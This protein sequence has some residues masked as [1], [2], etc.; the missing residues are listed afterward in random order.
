MGGRTAMA[1]EVYP[2]RAYPVALGEV[3][4]SRFTFPLICDVADVLRQHGYPRGSAADL[5]VLQQ[6]L[7]RFL[8]SGG[9]S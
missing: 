8:Y 7:Y 5:V 1:S 3:G 2:A 9:G 6:A 4:D